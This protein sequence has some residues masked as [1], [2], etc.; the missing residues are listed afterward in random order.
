MI[1]SC[2][3]ARCGRIVDGLPARDHA[4]FAVPAGLA[5]AAVVGRPVVDGRLGIHVVNVPP[6][7]VSVGFNE[8]ATSVKGIVLEFV[9]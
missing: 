1:A 5:P 8:L 6:N 7:W 4:D 2:T 9:T 3:N